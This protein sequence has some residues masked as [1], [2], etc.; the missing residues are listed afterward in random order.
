MHQPLLYLAS[1]SPRRREILESLGYR[2]ARLPADIDETPK[3]NEAAT[4]YVL[5]MACEKNAAALALWHQRQHA[6]PDAPVLTADT[7]VALDNHILGKPAN[8][9]EARQMLQALSGRR[10]QVLTAVCLCHNGAQQSF[11]QTSDVRFKALSNAEIDA[12]IASGEPLDKAGAYG[13]QGLGGIFVEHL[14]GSFTG[15]MGLPVFE[16]RQL[17]LDSGWPVPPFA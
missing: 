8:A 9:A 6:A 11:I 13:I 3:E 15:V 12:Y 5:R 10:H 17:L 1:G 7:T 14:Q 4:D 2:V 16:T